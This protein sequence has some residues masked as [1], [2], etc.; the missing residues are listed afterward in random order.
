M[1]A[2]VSR[3]CAFESGRLLEMVKAKTT[4][5]ESLLVLVVLETRALAFMEMAPNPILPHIM[6]E[7]KRPT[8]CIL[9]LVSFN[10]ARQELFP[11]CILPQKTRQIKHLFAEDT[12]DPNK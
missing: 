10:R 4:D 12:A 8:P 6:E 3:A 9:L 2:A 5:A 1:R 7:R 11:P